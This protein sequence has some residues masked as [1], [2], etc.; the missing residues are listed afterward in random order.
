MKSSTLLDQETSTNDFPSITLATSSI[1]K[2]EQM[3][4]SVESSV[5]SR[6]RNVI[7]KPRQID[8]RHSH[9]QQLTIVNDNHIVSDASNNPAQRSTKSKR[10][11]C[12]VRPKTRSS[13]SNSP[14]RRISSRLVRT[15]QIDGMHLEDNMK[16]H[17][18]LL[19][20][21][22]ERQLTHNVRSLRRV[23]RV[24]DSLI[25]EKE[26]WDSYHPAAFEDDFPTEHQ[27]AEACGL[28]VLDLRQIM[29][30]GQESRSVLVSANVGLVT[31]IAKRHFYA[32]KHASDSLGGVGTI[33]TLQDMIQEGNL[34]LM[35]AA[36][37][38]DADRG[39]RFSTYATYWIRQRI[40]RS[41]SDS[42][43]VIRLPAHGEFT[44]MFT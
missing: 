4:K 42:S 34:G 26:E 17:Q 36:E 14:R 3:L 23:V 28:S 29:V 38:F 16:D 9:K 43:R 18:R 5:S 40:L 15:I 12:L 11:N 7:R 19:S 33:L 35:K 37:R 24:R 41:I 21:E 31:S 44:L 20:R 8:I 27:W 32:L 10:R 2:E 22:E 25:Q 13:K 6:A 39:F 1:L 30:E